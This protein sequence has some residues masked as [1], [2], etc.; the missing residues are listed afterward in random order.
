VTGQDLRRG[1]RCCR[2][3]GAFAN[4]YPHGQII[5]GDHATGFS[6]PQVCKVCDFAKKPRAFANSENDVTHSCAVACVVDEREFAR[7]ALGR[8]GRPGMDSSHLLSRCS[9]PKQKCCTEPWPQG[10]PVVGVHVR[11][12]RMVVRR[13]PE[14]RSQ[15]AWLPDRGHSRWYFFPA[16]TC[17]FASQWRR[18][19]PD[20]RRL[21]Q[22]T[23]KAI[24]RFPQAPC[25]R[26]RR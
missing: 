24:S 18:C 14:F 2:D 16:Q 19:P 23:W 25:L 21:P 4:N 11:D 9:Q 17:L 3:Q 13:G 8:G 5:H 12:A 7:S 20:N 10:T 1:P 6:R 26:G 22:R 15:E